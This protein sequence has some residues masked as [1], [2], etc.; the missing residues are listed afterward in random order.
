MSSYTYSESQTF[1]L[2][3]ARHMAAKIATDLKRIQRFYGSPSD[4][5]IRMYE[6][7]AV[8]F[9]KAGYLAKVAYGFQRGGAWIEPTVSY[10]ARDLAGG[11]ANDDD[12]GKIRPGMDVTGA[13]FT[14]FMSYSAAYSS[15]SQSELENLAASRPF[16]RGSGQE[17]AVS[18]YLESDRTYSAGGRALDRNSV[19]SFR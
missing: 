12:P 10:T 3:H 11:V 19:R 5:D 4:N 8:L 9:M 1:T 16:I 15:A 14:S 2:T 6:E 7:E 18:G 17:P 13:H